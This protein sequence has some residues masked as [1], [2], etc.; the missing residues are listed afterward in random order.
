MAYSPWRDA[1]NAMQSMGSDLS[2]KLA[3]LARLQMSNNARLQELGM[4][5]AD[6]QSQRLLR[7]AQMR[8][9]QADAAEVERKMHVAKLLGESVRKPFTMTEG[10]TIEGAEQLRLSDIAQFGAESGALAG[11][12]MDLVKPIN[13]GQND[14]A[15]NP[16]TGEPV[17]FGAMVLSPGAMGQFPGR[18]PVVNPRPY[19][20]PSGSTP[21]NAQGQPTGPQ[22]AFRPYRSSQAGERLS[23][24]NALQARMNPFFEDLPQNWKT[25][26][27][28]ATNQAPIIDIPA[29]EVP[30]AA[31]I[32]VKGPNGETG[33]IED[34]DDLPDGWEVID[35]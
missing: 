34:G 8:K 1:G 14:V 5:A 31:R 23:K 21:M 19:F 11:H 3:G 6:M 33:T 7:D 9:Y 10:P 4:R 15:V 24:N 17:G 28:S 32:R 18:A 25:L 20:A 29:Q 26:V 12:G 16:I 13:I 35:E 30:Q 22:T 27:D 2:A